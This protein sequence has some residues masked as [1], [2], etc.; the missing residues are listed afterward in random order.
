MRLHECA[1]AP[2]RQLFV[3]RELLPQSRGGGTFR[4]SLLVAVVDL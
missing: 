1:V 4:I 2:G 3:R